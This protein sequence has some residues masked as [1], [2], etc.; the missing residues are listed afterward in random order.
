MRPELEKRNWEV[1]TVT[2]AMKSDTYT[3]QLRETILSIAKDLHH[4]FDALAKPDSGEYRHKALYAILE[5]AVRLRIETA[6]QV[7]PIRLPKIVPGSQFNPSTMEDRLS[8]ADEDDEE[9]DAAERREF[10][11]QM[12]LVPPVKRRVFDED[13]NFVKSITIRKGT[14]IAMQSDGGQGAS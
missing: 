6:R 12:V 1:Q 5:Q 8:A 7:S 10:T 2:L 4:E 13:G 11:V 3:D 14:V 9:E